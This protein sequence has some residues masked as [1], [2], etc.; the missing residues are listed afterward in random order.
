MRCTDG[1]ELPADLVLVAAGLVP[2]VELAEAAGLEVDNGIVVDEFCRTT[3]P[4]ILA[5]GDCA[6][7]PLPFLAHQRVRLESVPNALEH[8]RIA[9]AWLNGMAA[10]Y[11][12][13]P[14][15]WS[16][17]YNLKLQ[18]VGL[19]QGFQQEVERPARSPEGFIDFYLKEGRMIAADC[20]NAM[21]EFNAA[22]RLV[23]E[24]VP[25]SAAA[26]ADPGV[27]LKSLLP[28]KSTLSVLIGLCKEYQ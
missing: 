17:Q 19:A 2:N 27:D 12:L 10:P 1:A 25:V 9:A 20:V 8:A 16:D 28:P 26:L 18:S 24:R 21:L 22:K 7:F 6:N 4:D 14:W 5:I 13:V 3:D 23:A 11:D 15:F